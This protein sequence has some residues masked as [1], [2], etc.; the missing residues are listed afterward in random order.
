MT[1]EVSLGFACK[2]CFAVC[3]MMSEEDIPP[4]ILPLFQGQLAGFEDLA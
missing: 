3:Y 2:T 1:A 4:W